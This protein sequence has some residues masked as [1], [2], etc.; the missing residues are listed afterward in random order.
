M[1]FDQYIQY[2]SLSF[3]AAV[4][5][6]NFNSE[7]A[8]RILDKQ[9]KNHPDVKTVCTPIHIELF[10]RLEETLSVLNISKR[11]FIQ[12][13]IVEA[14]DRADAIMDE[15][16]IF[17]NHHPEIEASAEMDQKEKAS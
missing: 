13:A 7:A 11:A 17:E 5:G 14:L 12:M 2:R 16:D 6:E 1:K 3:K 10:E 4:D 15:V 8:D 9:I